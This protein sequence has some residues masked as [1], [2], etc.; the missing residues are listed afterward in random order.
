[1]NKTVVMPAVLAAGIAC[2]PLAQADP[3]SN[4]QYDQYMISHGMTTDHDLG[5]LLQEG[6]AACASLRSGQSDS[7]L[8]GAL[9]HRMSRAEAGNIVYAAHHYLCPGV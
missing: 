1:M 4:D 7:S 3:A 8:T 2:A 9:E 6:S 5:S